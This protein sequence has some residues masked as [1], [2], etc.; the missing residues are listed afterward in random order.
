MGVTTKGLP[1]P[2]PSAPVASG[3]ADIRALAEAIDP[4]LYAL[5]APSATPPATP[6][7]GQ[8]WT[9][10]A[11]AA[12]GIEW[13]FRYNAGSASA[14]KWEFVGGPAL[15]ASATGNFTFPGSGAWNQITPPDLVVP[16]TGEYLVSAM[17]Q[18]G[19][20]SV[21]GQ[22]YFGIVNASVGITPIGVYTAVYVSNYD[23]AALLTTISA[24]AGQTI[25]MAGVAPSANALAVARSFSLIPRRVS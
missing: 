17:C 5:P 6:L 24:S 3:A 22:F 13:V 8:L 7:D 1:W 25:R 12:N 10:P 11:D 9:F 23:T 14:S 21:P 19:I 20:A 18:L 16:R 4:K 2:A 15:V